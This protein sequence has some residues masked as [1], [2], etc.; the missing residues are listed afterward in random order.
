MSRESRLAVLDA[1]STRSTRRERRPGLA[2][3]DSVHGTGAD[4]HAHRPPLHYAKPQ[5]RTTRHQH[6]SVLS[7]S[8]CECSQSLWFVIVKLAGFPAGFVEGGGLKNRRLGECKMSIGQVLISRTLSVCGEVAERRWLPD[9]GSRTAFGHTPGHTAAAHC[10]DKGTIGI[11]LAAGDCLRSDICYSM[12]A[13][14]SASLRHELPGVTPSGLDAGRRE[15][16]HRRKCRIRQ[17]RPFFRWRSCVV[18]DRSP[19]AFL[20]TIVS[21]FCV[22]HLQSARVQRET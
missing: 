1:Q 11:S 18:R 10:L 16:D 13:A 19:K 9:D 20:V 5:R 17:H 4:T 15:N 7:T 22:N 3:G 8:L 6:A 12:T 2:V 14:I 21:G